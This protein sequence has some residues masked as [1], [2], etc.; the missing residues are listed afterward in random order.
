[1]NTPT[2]AVD[3]G[4]THLVHQSITRMDALL[5]G[6]MLPNVVSLKH[7]LGDHHARALT[8]MLDESYGVVR[9]GGLPMVSKAVV[10]ALVEPLL[11]EAKRQ[12]MTPH[13]TQSAVQMQLVGKVFAEV[14]EYMCHAASKQSEHPV[15]MGRVMSAL[16]GIETA[17]YEPIVNP[18]KTR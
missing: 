15:D 8:K 3:Q 14:A 18:G 17:L 16:V 7:V 13:A 9:V 12:D 5:Q 4:Y 11:A 2:H 6:E 10:D 1:M